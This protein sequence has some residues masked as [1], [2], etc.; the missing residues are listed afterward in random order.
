MSRKISEETICSTCLNEFK[1]S[2]LG[3]ALTESKI[4]GQYWSLVCK[5]CAGKRPF[6]P[7]ITKKTSKLKRS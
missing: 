1:Q 3:F 7:Y 6:K 4:G 2:E 5:K